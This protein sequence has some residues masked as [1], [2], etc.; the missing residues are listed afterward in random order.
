M[1]IEKR[2]LSYYDVNVKDWVAEAG[3]YTI[4]VGASSRDIKL[5]TEIKAIGN[6]DKYLVTEN[7]SWSKLQ[8]NKNISKIVAKYVGYNAVVEAVWFG[9]KTFGKF[10]TE[11]YEKNTELKG[12]VEKQ[13]KLTKEIIDEI[14]KMYN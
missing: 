5:T 4:K 12:N 10:L 13:S 6:S 8:E 7:S 3:K 14:N 1:Y 11:Q 9:D 2:D